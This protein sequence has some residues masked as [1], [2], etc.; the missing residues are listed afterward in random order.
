MLAVMSRVQ[1]TMVS[2]MPTVRLSTV[3]HRFMRPPLPL[4]LSLLGSSVPV[5]A[6]SR[7]DLSGLWS[8]TQRF[9]P[10]IRG[11]L[12]I[13]RTADAGGW[14]ADIAGFSVPVRLDGQSVRPPSP[15]G[16]GG[17]GVRTPEGRGGQGARFAFELP[18]GKG[19]LRDL[20]PSQQYGYLWNSMQY[21][22]QGR[23]EGK[24]RAF[25]AGGNGGQISMAIPDLDLVIAFTGGNYSDAATFRTQRTFMPE[26]LLP[27]VTGP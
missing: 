27:A 4:I 18:D 13:H 10:D 17:Q 6:Q 24:V 12:I 26:F 15:E 2:G 1:Y 19:A 14:R 23:P 11:P 21:P 5:A 9:G 16:R 3:S 25:F 7:P 20:T 8:A 22:Y